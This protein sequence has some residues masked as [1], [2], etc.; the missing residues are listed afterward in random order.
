MP[1]HK[2][3]HNPDLVDTRGLTCAMYWVIMCKTFPPR[4]LWHDPQ[5]KERTGK[6]LMN[7]WR[8]IV[9]ANVARSDYIIEYKSI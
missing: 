5:I 9:N 2:L 6:R 4:E 3:L 1:P 7:L 8:L